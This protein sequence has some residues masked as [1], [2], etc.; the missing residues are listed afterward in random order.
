MSDLVLQQRCPDLY[1]TRLLHLKATR[2]IP[3]AALTACLR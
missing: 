2:L 3:R 1:D